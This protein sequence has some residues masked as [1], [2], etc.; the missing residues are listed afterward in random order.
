MIPKNSNLVSGS[1]NYIK[2]VHPENVHR[3]IKT[4]GFVFIDYN[5]G[6]YA[7]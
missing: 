6:K 2:F 1:K 7:C 3:I 4:L 5:R